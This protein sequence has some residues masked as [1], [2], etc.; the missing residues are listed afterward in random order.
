MAATAKEQKKL[1]N[2]TRE[3]S[4]KQNLGLKNMRKNWE[5]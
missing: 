5:G 4:V 1:M 2:I 3:S